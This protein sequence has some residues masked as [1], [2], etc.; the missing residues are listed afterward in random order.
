ML[1]EY[2]RYSRRLVYD[3]C[4]K[5]D[6]I[7][8]PVN[9]EDCEKFEESTERV[10]RKFWKKWDWKVY[11][12]GDLVE[13]EQPES[14]ES[15]EEHNEQAAYK[16]DKSLN[17]SN[18]ADE[19]CATVNECTEPRLPDHT[20]KRVAIRR[21][22]TRSLILQALA[23]RISRLKDISKVSTKKEHS[24]FRSVSRSAII[25]SVCVPSGPSTISESSWIWFV[26]Y[27]FSLIK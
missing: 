5:N 23:N 19:R 25:S 26:G 6:T 10:Q 1:E 7:T 4:W 12:N 17:Q 8:L 11:C 27:G 2:S 15:S 14:D 24:S 3:G 13:L 9:R 20:I 18:K 21:N 22:T 16:S